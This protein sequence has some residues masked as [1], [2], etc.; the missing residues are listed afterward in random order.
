MDFDTKLRY[1]KDQ[2]YGEGAEITETLL[3]TEKKGLKGHVYMELLV[4][5]YQSI[6]FLHNLEIPEEQILEKQIEVKFKKP[7]M[8]K[9]LLLDL[10]ETLVHCVKRPNPLRP[11]TV[12]L[13]ITTPSGAVV[14]DVGFNIRPKCNELLVSAN[15]HYEVCVFTASTPQYADSIIDYLD[16]T[17]T[18]IQ[19]RFY[20]THCIK[21][22][23][24]EYIKDLRVFK[25]ID[26]KNILLID[27]AFYS[28]GAQ[29][30]NGI[31]IASFKEDPEDLEFEYLIPYLEECASYD[32]VR[33]CNRTK[34]PLQELFDTP[35]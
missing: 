5:I 16:P 7:N 29:L 11:P 8:T 25:N 9:M 26:L 28:F 1:K 24:G 34:F 6:D 20:R 27:N 13:D 22:Q 17:G 14:K 18:L 2:I 3:E 12:K 33:D 10:D 35:F 30:Q 19:H 23:G 21:T 31:P 15:R 32:D 4:H